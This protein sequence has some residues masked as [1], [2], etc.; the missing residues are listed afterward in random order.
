MMNAGATRLF[1]WLDGV[2]VMWIQ[3]VSDHKYPQGLIP[4]PPEDPAG[5]VS[6]G[7]MDKTGTFLN[8]A[9][10]GNRRTGA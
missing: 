10:T 1:S 6:P 9:S 8:S 4:G 5:A 7:R 3:F 2:G